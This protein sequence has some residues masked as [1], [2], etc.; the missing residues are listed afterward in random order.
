MNGYVIVVRVLVSMCIDADGIIYIAIV[1][2]ITAYGV[3]VGGCPAVLLVSICCVRVL[4][5]IYVVAIVHVVVDG[6][7]VAD[8]IADVAGCVVVGGVVVVDTVYAVVLSLRLFMVVFE[9]Y[10]CLW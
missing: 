10:C 2:G 3:A 8:G 7:G 5:T 4:C 9:W 1:G 6:V